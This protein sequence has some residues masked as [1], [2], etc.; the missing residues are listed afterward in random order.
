MRSSDLRNRPPLELYRFQISR[1]TFD[2]KQPKFIAREPW[3]GA[4]SCTGGTLGPIIILRVLTPGPHACSKSSV[5]LYPRLPVVFLKFFYPRSEAPDIC[6]P[7][8]RALG[9]A[10][11]PTASRGAGM[12]REIGSAIPDFA[13]DCVSGAVYRKYPFDRSNSGRSR[14]LRHG[15]EGRRAPSADVLRRVE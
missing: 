12:Q 6:T 8:S 7:S 4:G 9:A 10:P 13:G 11:A 14:R 1:N 2:Q 5:E 3:L 15:D